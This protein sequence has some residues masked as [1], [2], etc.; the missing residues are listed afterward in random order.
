MRAG[1]HLPLIDFAGEGL[2]RRRLY[3]AVDAARSNGFSWVAANDHFIFPAP[4]LD[5]LTA[6]AVV[7]ERCGDMGLAT[8]VALPTLRGPLALAKALISLD[9][10]SDGPLVAGLG[11]GSSAMDYAAVGIR[12]DER[13][14]RFD[15]AVRVLR[16]LLTDQPVAPGLFYPAPAGPVRPHPGARAVPI[17]IASWGS[18]VGLRRVAQLGDGW[19]ASAYHTTPEAFAS[20]R[21]ALGDELTQRGRQIDTFPNAVVS[22]WTRVTQ[23]TSEARQVIDAVLSPLLG[24]DPAELSER[25]CV[26]PPDQCADLLSRYARAGAEQ[27][28][29]WPVGDEARQVE[30]LATRV[31]TQVSG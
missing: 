6:L 5:G 9:L 21:S 10:L 24:Q 8:T 25:V 14:P 19:L 16:G 17:W 22:M 4:W 31:L 3:A 1:V 13:W 12:L 2:S 11:P 18:R 28:V 27:V 20:R 30:L 23:S 26:G 29:F 7:A 15:D